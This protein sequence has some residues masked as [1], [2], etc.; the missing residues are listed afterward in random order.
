MNTSQ[1]LLPA[2]KI[3]GLLAPPKRCARCGNF[4]NLTKSHVPSRW[5]ITNG[6]LSRKWRKVFVTRKMKL[7]S[8]TKVFQLCNGCHIAYSEREREIVARFMYAAALEMIDTHE[9]FIRQEVG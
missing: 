4:H 8:T 1:K 3:A 5:I 9:N 2:P 6:W 7:K